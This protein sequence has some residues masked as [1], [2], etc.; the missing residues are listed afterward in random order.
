M[1]QTKRTAGMG[2]EI[3]WCP[4]QVWSAGPV[5]TILADL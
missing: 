5:C 2:H 1:T 3:K 4:E